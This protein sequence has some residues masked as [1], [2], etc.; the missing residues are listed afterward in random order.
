[1]KL[2][3]CVAGF[4]IAV[5]LLV[6]CSKKQPEAKA[7]LEQAADAMAKAPP[8]PP[9]PGPEPQAAPDPGIP[10]TPTPEPVAVAPA[11]EVRQAL[12]EY[13]AGKMED[14]VTRLQK[15]R[16]VNALTPQ[17]RMALQDSIAAV[18][19]EVYTLAS[20]GDPRAI[21]AVRQYEEMQ[22]RRR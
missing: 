14:A 16:R 2:I 7:A 5:A 3:S 18:M 10:D 13:R 20:Q 8:A 17:Q 9:A 21:A 22:T 4:A 6:G 19:N 11:Q 15:L 1:M 12:T